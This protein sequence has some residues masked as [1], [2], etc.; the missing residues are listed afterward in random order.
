[1]PAC[2][3]AITRVLA[4]WGALQHAGTSVV[5]CLQADMLACWPIVSQRRRGA[6][7][8]GLSVLLRCTPACRHPQLLACWHAG[9]LVDGQPAREGGQGCW[10][11]CA[12][13]VHPSISCWYVCVLACRPIAS[14][15]GREGG[16]NAD[17]SVLLGCTLACQH[18]QLL[19][20]WH[21][22]MLVDGQ[23]TREGGQ[24]CWCVCAAGVY[25][26]IVGM[27][28]CACWSMATH[29]AGL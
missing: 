25:P 23:P 11:V 29:L 28:A 12:A 1:M 13:G 24:G 7:D 17:V 18:P 21:T 8:A 27:L 20:C 16:K 4:C 14:Q 26:S 3:P 22:D 6:K 9:M 10:S 19:V 15:R 2:Q 5:A